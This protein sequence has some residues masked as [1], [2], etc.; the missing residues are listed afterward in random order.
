MCVQDIH[1]ST[2]YPCVIVEIYVHLKLK[3]TVVACGIFKGS[4]CMEK[5]EQ[6][7]EQSKGGESYGTGYKGIL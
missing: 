1:E 4:I 6:M 7:L 5:S 3:E 2:Y